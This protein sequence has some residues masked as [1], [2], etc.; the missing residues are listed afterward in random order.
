M[1]YVYALMLLDWSYR[2]GGSHGTKVAFKNLQFQWQK[3]K[4]SVS[5]NM[6]YHVC[7]REEILDPDT[8]SRYVP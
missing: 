3:K 4:S 6:Y 7:T 2:I 5:C 1:V 8:A